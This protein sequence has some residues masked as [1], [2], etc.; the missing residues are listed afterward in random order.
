[1]TT[2][3]RATVLIVIVAASGLVLGA[4]LQGIGDSQSST[5]VAGLPDSLE[6]PEAKEPAGPRAVPSSD[7]AALV[8]ALTEM[9]NREIIERQLLA[10]EVQ[11]LRE[12]MVQLQA[13]I[14]ANAAEGGA[15]PSGGGRDWRRRREVTE[16][17]FLDAGFDSGQ[18]A[19]LNQI[20]AE[21]AIQQLYLLDRAV[22]EGWMGSQRYYEER[23][24]IPGSLNA[25]RAEL[26]EAAYDRYLY[27]LGRPNRVTVR[28]VMANSAADQSGLQAGD[29]LYRY[30]GERLFSRR[31][32]RSATRSGQLGEAIPVEV[33]RDGQRLQVYIPRGPLGV[34][35]ELS[36]NKP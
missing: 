8:E 20:T 35:M 29:V 11:I 12:E 28:N 9:V 26:G 27:A 18:A 3:P 10:E 34:R 5:P 25:L 16:Q 30:A 13:S 19:Y 24:R 32:L 23:D 15:P 6:T 22:R 31:E 2:V 4:L 33:I 36:S 17:S 21:A 7:A 1:M 14:P